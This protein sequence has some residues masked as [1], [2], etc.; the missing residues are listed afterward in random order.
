MFFSLPGEARYLH[1]NTPI[2]DTLI[3]PCM[4]GPSVI[5]KRLQLKKLTVQPAEDIKC[6][7]FTL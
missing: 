6:E 7:G 3:I 1:T 2:P 4:T 5:G